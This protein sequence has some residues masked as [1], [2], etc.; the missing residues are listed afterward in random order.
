[1]RRRSVEADRVQARVDDIHPNLRRVSILVP[2]V[3][4]QPEEKEDDER[5]E[6]T[7]AR[8]RREPQGA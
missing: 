3:S 1:M 6:G 5:D 2:A 7:R 8:A 4:W